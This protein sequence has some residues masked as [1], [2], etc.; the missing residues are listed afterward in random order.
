MPD[1]KH[2][3]YI[4]AP[5][6]RALIQGF[7]E[8]YWWG[9]GTFQREPIR[10]ALFDWIAQYDLPFNGSVIDELFTDWWNGRQEFN[11]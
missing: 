4:K 10:L 5:E 8:G 2:N 6:L 7:C 3:A 9:H 11:D 1:L